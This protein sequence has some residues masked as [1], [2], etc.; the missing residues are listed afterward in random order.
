[1]MPEKVVF[2]L[3]LPTVMFLPPRTIAPLPL[4]EPKVVPVVVR[5]LMSSVP[6]LELFGLA[7]LLSWTAAVPPFALPV[8][9][10]LAAPPTKLS[11]VLIEY[12]WP[13]FAVR[14]AGPA[15]EL[16]WKVTSAPG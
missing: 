16:P 2:A 15:L 8:K 12:D 7:L 6:K 10:N 3:R 14:M 5:P 4:I 9:A 11:P 13:A 1:M